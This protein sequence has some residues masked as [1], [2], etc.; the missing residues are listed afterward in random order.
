MK[1]PTIFQASHGMEADRAREIACLAHSQ[2]GRQASCASMHSP[3]HRWGP[4]RACES[5]R[6]ASPPVKEIITVAPQKDLNKRLSWLTRSA[7]PSEPRQGGDHW[8]DIGRFS[9]FHP[10]HWPKGSG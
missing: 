10:K 3:G 4:L 9:S 8:R 7:R 6:V 2:A 1:E 5:L